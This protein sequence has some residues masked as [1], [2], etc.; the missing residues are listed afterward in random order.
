MVRSQFPLSGSGV[1][2][3]VCCGDEILVDDLSIANWCNE[4]VNEDCPE[5]HLDRPIH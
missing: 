3:C 4:C 2:R 1:T 5:W